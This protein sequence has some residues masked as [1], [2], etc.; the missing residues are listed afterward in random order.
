M[1]KLLDGG[2]TGVSAV[3]AAEGSGSTSVDISPAESGSPS[4]LR[5]WCFGGM[6]STNDDTDE[7]REER[8][9]SIVLANFRLTLTSVL[10]ADRPLFSPRC[11]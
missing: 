4:D 1:R 3:D 7:N 10:R 9:L 8:F 11:Y 2:D 6:R 5:G